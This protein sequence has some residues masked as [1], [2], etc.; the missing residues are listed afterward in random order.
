MRFDRS[1]LEDVREA[2]Y[3]RV[4]SFDE[5]L[6]TLDGVIQQL[7]AGETVPL[8]A[9]GSNGIQAAQEMYK[10]FRVRRDRV[11]ELAGRVSDFLH[12]DEGDE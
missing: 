6:K 4:E 12:A 3:S 5:H 7:D 9:R 1:E 8:F 10:G 11:Q 2:L